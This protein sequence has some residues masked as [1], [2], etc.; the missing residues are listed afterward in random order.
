[1]RRF[2]RI[3]VQLKDR[4]NH[5]FN[6]VVIPQEAGVVVYGCTADEGEDAIQPPWMAIQW[7]YRSLFAV[8]GS[9]FRPIPGRNDGVRN[10]YTRFSL[11]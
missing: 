9:G 1:M 4:A 7:I 8:L 3:Y 10:S 6:S 11:A 2:P 5:Q